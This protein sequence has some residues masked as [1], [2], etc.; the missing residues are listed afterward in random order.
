M[1]STAT[2]STRQVRNA[3]PAGAYTA[4][5]VAD[6]DV[7]WQ[8]DSVLDADGVCAIVSAAAREITG[9]DAEVRVRAA[10]DRGAAVLRV[11]VP[12]RYPM[13]I[14]QVTT[15][16]RAHVLERMRQR[17]GITVRRLD[18]EVIELT[19]PAR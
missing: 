14:W 7:A 1:T 8:S 5:P 19:E 4:F 16:C 11:Q 15:A 12:V 13:P 9:V 17:C 10:L 2:P 3:R 6:S 18:I